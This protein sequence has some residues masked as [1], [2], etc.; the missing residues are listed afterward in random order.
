MPLNLRSTGLGSGVDKDRADYAVYSR[1]QDV[2]RRI[3][4]IRGGPDSLR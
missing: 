1:G 2:G 4:E 3:Y